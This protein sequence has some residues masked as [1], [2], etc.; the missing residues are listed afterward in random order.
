MAKALVAYC[1][2]FLCVFKT[3][4]THG[5]FA[6]NYLAGEFHKTQVKC[7]NVLLHVSGKRVSKLRI[8]F[9]VRMYDLLQ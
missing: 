3:D 5:L 8:C 6:E 9:F 4:K 1:S 7:N 2:C